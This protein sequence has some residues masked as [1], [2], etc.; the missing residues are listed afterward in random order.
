M[1]YWEVG[2]LSIY[3]VTHIFNSV[4]APFIFF[5]IALIIYVGFTFSY[6]LYSVLEDEEKKYD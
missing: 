1:F 4:W 3:L 5:N 6:N 2:L